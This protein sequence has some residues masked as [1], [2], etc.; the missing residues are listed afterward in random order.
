MEI[1]IQG[2][3]AEMIRQQVDSGDYQSPEALVYEA[4]K[5]LAKQKVQ[6]RIRSGLADVENGR[7]TELRSDNIEEITETIVDQSLQ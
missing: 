3:L 7:F 4:L 2:T 6:E 5:A 1:V